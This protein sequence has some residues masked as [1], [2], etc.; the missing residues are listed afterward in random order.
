MHDIIHMIQQAM[1]FN[2][3]AYED[4]HWHITYFLKICDTFE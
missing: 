4:P 2:G 3:F 1:Q